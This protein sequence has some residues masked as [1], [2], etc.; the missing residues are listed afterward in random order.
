MGGRKI[1]LE[2]TKSIEPPAEP[3]QWYNRDALINK[4]L[5]SI[6]HQTYSKYPTRGLSQGGFRQVELIAASQSPRSPKTKVTTPWRE[7]PYKAR[8]PCVEN[9]W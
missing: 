6:R 4:M 3:R 8:A 7:N 9:I 1:C 2:V 5:V